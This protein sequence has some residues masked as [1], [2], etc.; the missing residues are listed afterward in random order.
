[1]A[2]RS[3]RCESPPDFRSALTPVAQS[4]PAFR[5][6]AF[7][8][9]RTSTGPSV[10]SHPCRSHQEEQALI[11]KTLACLFPVLVALWSTACQGEQR[12]IADYATARPLFW[13]KVYA[14]GGTTLYCER[15]FHSRRGRGINIEHV[16]PMSWVAYS[17]KCGKRWQCRKTSER[18]NRIEADMHN[19]YPADSRINEERS[20]F[21]FGYIRGEKRA[22][23]AC[24]FEVD[25]S[26]RL[27]EPRPGARGRVAR[28]MLYMHDEYDPYLRPALGRQ[29]LKWHF[30]YSPDAEEKHRN[31]AIE[32]LQGT[33]N[34]YIDEP[35]LARGLRF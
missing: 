30:Q 22:F 11:E 4:S 25:E 8:V 34:R 7:E 23:G 18:F 24:D 33:R 1:M 21:R 12:A 5:G 2:G 19:L 29:L 3:D 13:D 10:T 15:P 20:S 14:D 17:L 6:G 32:A 31:Q 16:F 28:A 9:L 26:R 35:G 27:A